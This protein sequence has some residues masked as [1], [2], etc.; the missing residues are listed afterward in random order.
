MNPA[1]WTKTPR[2]PIYSRNTKPRLRRWSA[3]LAAKR[4][5]FR[6]ASDAVPEGQEPRAG[7]L[8]QLHTVGK[9]TKEAENPSRQRALEIEFLK[10]A[11]KNAP[12]PRNVN[13]Y[14]VAGPAASP[15]QQDAG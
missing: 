15:S 2:L 9:A 10:G 1:P 4:A 11:L 5:Q 6:C 3:W 14:V 12:R 7:K 8:L 13:T